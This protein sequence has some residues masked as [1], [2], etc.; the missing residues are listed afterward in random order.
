MDRYVYY[1]FKLIL[2]RY[3]G[4]TGA[5]TR[6]VR[7]CMYI[8]MYVYRH[9]RIYIHIYIYIYVCIYIYMYKYI[10]I[11]MYIH[12]YIPEYIPLLPRYPDIT[13][14]STRVVRIGGSSGR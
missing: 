3:P 1:K 10:Y 7:I 12:I 13:G 6:V 8:Y 14:A 9:I 4:T 5:S 11:H 2:L